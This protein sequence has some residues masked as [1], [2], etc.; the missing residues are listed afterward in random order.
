LG[1]PAAPVIWQATQA[2]WYV[3]APSAIAAPEAAMKRLAKIAVAVSFFIKY[4][5]S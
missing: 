3:A 1:A 5:L 4:Y 2:F